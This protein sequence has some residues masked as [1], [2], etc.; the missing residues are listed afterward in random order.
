MSP[1]TAWTTVSI[2][3]AVIILAI[4]WARRRWL[5]PPDNPAARTPEPYRS[6]HGHSGQERIPSLDE[7]Q[8]WREDWTDAE[9][10]ALRDDPAPPPARTPEWSFRRWEIEQEQWLEA[11]RREA[12]EYSLALKS[13]AWADPW[14]IYR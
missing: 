12:H 4:G 5:A 3:L 13:G 8:R 6:R 10:A 9:L 7:L 11:R 1:F 2:A 14:W